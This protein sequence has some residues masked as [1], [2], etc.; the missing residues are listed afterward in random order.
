MITAAGEGVK[1]E[2]KGNGG[3]ADELITEILEKRKSE[4]GRA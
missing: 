1:Q 3:T 2:R 4:K